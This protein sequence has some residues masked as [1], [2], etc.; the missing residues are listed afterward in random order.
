LW[1]SL[2]NELFVKILKANEGSACVSLAAHINV[3]WL[4]LQVLWRGILWRG[5]DT[6]AVQLSAG[7]LSLR[8]ALFQ[9]LRLI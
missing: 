3:L 9:E 6:S 5:K 4:F 7:A 8:S 1:V 2:V